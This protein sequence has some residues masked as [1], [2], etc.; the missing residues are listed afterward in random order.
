MSSVEVMLIAIL[1]AAL[2]AILVAA[3]VV[4]SF[5]ILKSNKHLVELSLNDRQ[6]NIRRRDGSREKDEAIEKLKE[7]LVALRGIMHQ[8]AREAG[9]EGLNEALAEDERRRGLIDEVS[10]DDI[11]TGGRRISRSLG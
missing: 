7:E 11:G 6:Q 9:G 1:V 10:E 3:L 2:I 4:S 8:Q 5:L